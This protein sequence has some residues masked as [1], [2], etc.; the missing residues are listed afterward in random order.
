MR[1][2][3]FEIVR[4]S[5]YPQYL[6]LTNYHLS[7]ISFLGYSDTIISKSLRIANDIDVDPNS[8]ARWGQVSKEDGK[9]E[10]EEKET[11]HHES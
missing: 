2:T 8:N 10:E 3:F 6:I 4:N 9:E 11:G 1:D 7:T 5:K